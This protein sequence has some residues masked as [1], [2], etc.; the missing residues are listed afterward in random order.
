M[1]CYRKELSGSEILIKTDTTN[2]V[3]NKLASRFFLIVIMVVAAIVVFVYLDQN[4][5]NEVSSSTV[6]PKHDPYVQEY[7]LPQ[8]SAP[9]GLVV[10]KSGLVWVT[11]GNATLY[12]VDP[13]SGQVKNYD[14]KGG[15]APYEKPGVHSVMVW[16]IVESG[17]GKIWFSP[18]GSTSIWRFDPSNG[19]FDS[20][21]SETGAP[22]QMKADGDKIW[23]TTLRGDT[24]GVI[25][26]SQN[27]TYVVSTFDTVS[28]ANPAGIFLQNDSVW[29]AN[30]GSQNIFQY[31]INQDN[32]TTKSISTIREIP[33]GNATLFSS[34]TDLFVDKNTLWLTEHG[35]SFFT[36]YDLNS[37]KITR[38]PTS[39][40][41]FNTTT[42]PFWIRG[43]DDPKVL[44]FNEHQG[45]KIGRFDVSNKTL[46][47][48]S[49][50]SLP[51]DGY[52]TYP[53]N[54][55]QDPLDEKI[56]WFSEWNTDKIGVING[57]VVVPFEINLNATQITLKNH[58]TNVVNLKITSDLNNS[59]RLFFN[60]SS[61]ITP[62]AALGNLSVEFSSNVVTLPHNDAVQITMRDGGVDPGN[63]TVGISASDGVVTTTKFLDLSVLP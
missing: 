1:P 33:S 58:G 52:L 43:I 15:K 26:K 40:N 29:I 18:L 56:L 8:G 62:T 61:S 54:I 49:I 4:S 14:I 21:L 47:E 10:D 11:S 35:T 38:Y 17:D 31:K 50:P 34:P 60:A 59:N 39:Q 5:R 2:L 7:S 20:Y 44:W 23:F 36:S 37:G 46:T 27:G 25:E 12:S 48:Y 57:H 42:L 6:V 16:A 13:Q 41:T 32:Y 55:S 51:K 45:N 9:N 63:Y 19:I 28:H 53:L 24:I 3:L 30:V 22:F